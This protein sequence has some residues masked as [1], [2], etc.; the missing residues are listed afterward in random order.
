ME[1]MFLHAAGHRVARALIGGLGFRALKQLFKGSRERILGALMGKL[2][3]Q[4]ESG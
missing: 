2:G 1:W 3:M 4:A